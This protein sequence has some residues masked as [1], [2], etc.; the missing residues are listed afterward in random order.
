MAVSLVA[1]IH[2]GNLHLSRKIGGRLVAGLND[3]AREIAEALC[4]ARRRVDP[5]K[6]L[7]IA[8][9]LFDVADPTP[10]LMKAA[11]D[12]VGAGGVDGE[13]TF[14]LVGNHDQTSDVPGH[15]ALGPLSHV[16]YVIE[17]PWLYDCQDGEQVIFL[18]FRNI[19]G[20]DLVREGLERLKHLLD[21]QA[22]KLL[23][24]HLGIEDESTPPWMRG[25]N[26]S[27]LLHELLELMHR[28]RIEACAAGNWHQ[29]RSWEAQRDGDTYRVAQIGALCPTGWDN[30]GLEGYGSLIHW[31]PGQ[32]FEREE[33]PGPRFIA[34]EPVEEREGFHY[35]RKRVVR[36][37]EE[38]RDVVEEN[39]V[40]VEFDKL[41]ARK[42]HVKAAAAV[43][44]ATGL[45]ASIDAYCA[46][47]FGNGA[48]AVADLAKL[49]VSK[50]T[51]T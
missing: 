50:V 44:H 38:A 4:E 2:L 31:T 22:P 13:N 39:D 19:P 40:E 11:M 51:C 25:H 21:P 26:D 20:R 30:P 14:F 17:G 7:I 24:V 12:A 8:G 10:E 9:D 18:P 41:V 23:V 28:Y 27:I 6:P 49:F 33:I 48:Q 32:P 43:R 47:K 29:Y 15:N 45:A 42:A 46:E 35:Y 36:S 34:D 5:D 3:R 1:D 16:G 37:L